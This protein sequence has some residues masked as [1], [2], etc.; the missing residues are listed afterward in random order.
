MPI[1]QAKLFTAYHHPTIIHD[2]LPPEIMIAERSTWRWVFWSTSIVDVLV[3]ISGLFFLLET[4]APY[5]LEQKAKEIRKKLDEENAPHREV[6]T[7]FESAEPRSWQHIFAK[8][9]TRPFQLFAYETI[10][11]ILGVYMAFVYGIFY[12]FLTTMPVIFRDNY[13]EG[14]GIGGLHYIALGIGL[15]AS[16][17]INARFMDRIYIHF[18]KRNNGVGEPEFRLPTTIPGSIILPFGLL[19]S[20]WAAQHKLH[21]IAVD[22][23]IAC[24]GAGM[25]L[26]FQGIQTYVVDT[27]T[28]HAAS[29]LAAVSTL[30][31]LAGFGFPL[32]APSMYAKL[33]YGKG[34]TIL[35]ALAIA[36]GCPA[37]ILLWKFGKRIRMSSRYANKQAHPRSPPISA[38]PTLEASHNDHHNEKKNATG[39]QDSISGSGNVPEGQVRSNSERMRAERVC[40]GDKATTNNEVL[41]VD[42]DGPSD[43]SNPKNWPYRKKWVA[44]LVVSAVTFISPVSSSMIAPA[45]GQVAQSFGITSNVLIAMTTSVFLLGFGPLSEIFGRTRVLQSSYLFYL[46]WNTGCG[47]ST[48]KTQLLV[49]RFLAGLG[50]AAPLSIG[51]GVLGDIW[52][53]EERGK[54]IAVYSLAPLLGPAIGPVN[55][56]MGFLV[57]KFSRCRS[58]NNWSILPSR[59]YA[60]V[61]SVDCGQFL[62]PLKNERNALRIELSLLYSANDRLRWKNIFRTALTRPFRL[63]AYESIVQILGIYMAFVY[64][65]FYK[66]V[67]YYAPIIFS[68]IYNE[69]PGTGGLHYI[70]LGLGLTLSSQ[71]SARYIDRIYIHFKN[72]NNGVG[73]P[74]FRLPTIILGSMLVPFGLLLSGWSAQKKIHWIAVDIKIWKGNL[75][76]GAGSNLVFQGVQTYVVDTFTLHA[77]SALAAVNTLR[78]LAGFGFPLFSP[79]MYAKIGYGKG[80][81]ILACLA[82]AIGCPAPILLWKYGRR[83]RIGS[84]YAANPKLLQPLSAS[85][86]IDSTA[87]RSN[88]H[89]IVR[90]SSMLLD[91]ID[92]F[93]E[94][95]LEQFVTSERTMEHGESGK[96]TLWVDWDGPND[97]ADPKQRNGVLPSWFPPSPLSPAVAS[98]MVAPATEQIAA[99]FGIRSTALLAMTISVFILGYGPLSEIYGR[100]RVLQLANLFFFAWNLGCGFAQNRSQ[101]IAFRFLSGIGGSAPLSVGG[102]VLGDMWAPEERGRAIAIY[103]LA[104]LLGPVVG[105]IC[106]G[107]LVLKSY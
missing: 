83:I 89:A 85:S 7:I 84:R 48:S 92:G 96:D 76:V 53:P 30:R 23:G 12:L 43:P 98:S 40:N 45:S 78:S 41:L 29:A 24:V 34:N 37:P 79:A 101:L 62:N 31:S 25:I 6:R 80:D 69:G 100:S 51:G 38:G 71:A 95:E 19:L 60:S 4:F 28:L 36:L 20:G 27:F 26:V 73:E 67:H 104:P 74:E 65:I 59:M 33:G 2:R 1:E 56:A 61:S 86:K 18:E 46:A 10:V 87:N 77:A 16:S 42:W 88:S 22:F 105:P 97:K 72:K 44:T 64:G 21:W 55:L 103:S 39:V 81:T 93:S 66:H 70:A 91:D 47:F 106:G 102:G 75:F 17:Q 90:P 52:L 63:F 107:W 9:L 82:I 99:E 57:N 8:A 3:Q 11:Q 50:G 14:P 13:H 15:S 54:A 94:E 68:S 32:F 5:L 49:F 58:A 35:A